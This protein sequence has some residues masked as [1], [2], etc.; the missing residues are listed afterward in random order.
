MLN[1][2]GK[3]K[4]FW[5]YKLVS[6]FYKGA[7]FKFELLSTNSILSK[8][9]FYLVLGLNVFMLLSGIFKK[10]WSLVIGHSLALRVSRQS[11]FLN[12]LNPRGHWKDMVEKRRKA[13]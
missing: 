3:F 7:I 13:R 8:L 4:V 6:I 11:L 12:R 10:S 1:V 9:Y 5:I 2:S